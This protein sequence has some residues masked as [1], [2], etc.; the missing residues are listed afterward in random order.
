MKEG[1]KKYQAEYMSSDHDPK[2]NWKIYKKIKHSIRQAA[3]RLIKQELEEFTDSKSSCEK[4][5][6]DNQ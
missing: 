3:K 6:H 2:G 1:Q 5:L 4:H